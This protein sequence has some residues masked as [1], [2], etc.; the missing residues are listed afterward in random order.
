VYGFTNSG[1][2]LR[3]DRMSGA[4]EVVS[5]ATGSDQFWGA[6]VTTTVP[7]LI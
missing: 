5:T 3:I 4:A 1:Q 2:L 7:F 6:G